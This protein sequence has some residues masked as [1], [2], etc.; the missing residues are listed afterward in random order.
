MSFP[1]PFNFCLSAVL[2]LDKGNIPKICMLCIVLINTALCWTFH[3]FGSCFRT[4]AVILFF[5]NFS[6]FVL[7]VFCLFDQDVFT[8]NIRMF[9][10]VFFLL[11]FKNV[12]DNCLCVLVLFIETFQL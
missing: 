6:L 7:G 12:A 8:E 3:V 10:I 1:P 2:G 9:C 4:L 5:H 11:F